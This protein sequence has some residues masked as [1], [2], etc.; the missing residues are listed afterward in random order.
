[1]Q[2][3]HHRRSC[4][5]LRIP[6]LHQQ[7]PAPIPASRRVVR[8]AVPRLSRG[9]SQRAC[10]SAYTPFKPSDT[11]Q[12]SPPLSYRGCWHRVSRDFFWHRSTYLAIGFL[13]PKS[14]LR[15]EGLPPTR[16]VAGS[17]FRPLPNIRYCSPPWRSGQ[18]LSPDEAGRPL[19]PATRQCLGG[20][21][22]HQL[23][24]RR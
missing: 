1:M 13:K 21:L 8:E 23:A 24:D 16:G 3:L 4:R 9:I 18:C 22:P 20:P 2:R 15:P 14:G 12:R 6:P 5:Y 11:E 19:S 7:F 10:S 17:G